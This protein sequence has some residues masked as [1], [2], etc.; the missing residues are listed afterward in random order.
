MH[1]DPEHLIRG[2]E[3]GIDPEDRPQRAGLDLIIRG[4]E[5]SDR[6]FGGAGHDS[7]EGG[8]GADVIRGGGGN[9]QIDGGAGDDWIA[10]GPAQAVPDRYENSA[11][12][13]NNT[14]AYASLLTEDFSQLRRTVGGNLLPVAQRDVFIDGLNFSYGDPADW[15]LLRTPEALKEFGTAK[16]AQLLKNAIELEF[17]GAPTETS[18]LGNGL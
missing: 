5:G 10:G 12:A 8:P 4:G 13:S 1:A 7:I 3:W 6:L 2:S 15:Y 16:A 17:E 9:D 14:V 11:G 18:I